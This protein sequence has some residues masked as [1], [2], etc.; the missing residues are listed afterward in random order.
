MAEAALSMSLAL[1]VG[2]MTLPN[3]ALR[4]EASCAAGPWAEVSCSEPL[5]RFVE[6]ETSEAKELDGRFGILAAWSSDESAFRSV[7]VH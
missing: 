5:R 1:P 3:D 6:P 4:G 7:S 2:V